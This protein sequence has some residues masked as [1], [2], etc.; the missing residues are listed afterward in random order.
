MGIVGL[1]T[2][3]AP[4]LSGQDLHRHVC[5]EE[6]I[7]L[8]IKKLRFAGETEFVRRHCGILR[9]LVH[10]PEDEDAIVFYG[11]EQA[12]T[13]YQSYLYLPLHMYTYVYTNMYNI[14]I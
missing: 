3:V 6:A 14:Y 13:D 10:V 1:Q 12:P 8:V 2:G 5:M 4:R 7:L 11:I 9:Y